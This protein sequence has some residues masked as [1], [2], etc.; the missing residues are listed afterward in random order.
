MYYHIAVIR[1]YVLCCDVVSYV[2]ADSLIREIELGERIAVFGIPFLCTDQNVIIIEV[3]DEMFIR[4]CNVHLNLASLVCIYNYVNI[5]EYLSQLLL[6]RHAACYKN[7]TLYLH[8][9]F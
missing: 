5:M 8:W 2:I 7:Q 9:Y 3:C 4:L 6:C 1:L